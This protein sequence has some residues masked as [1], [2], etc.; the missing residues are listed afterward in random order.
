MA[1]PSRFWDKLAERYAARPIK[2]VA[3]YDAMLADAAG[4]SRAASICG[5]IFPACSP[6]STHI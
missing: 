4:R 5:T 6:P 1:S 3:A 2:D